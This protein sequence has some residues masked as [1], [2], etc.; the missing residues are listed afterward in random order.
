MDVLL[1]HAYFLYDDPHELAVMKPYPP[2]GLLYV[3]SH[4]KAHGVDSSIF[5][6]T[7]SRFDELE[8]CLLEQRPPVVGIYSNLMT[9][10]KVL[11]VIAAAKQAGSLVVV[12]GPDPANYLDEYL[13][14]GADVIAIGE[15]ELTLEEL[16][17][18]LQKFGPENLGGIQGIAFR[19]AA[20]AIVR[21]EP[22]PLIADLDAQPLPDRAAIDQHAYVNVWREHHGRGS[23]SLITARGCP[24]T[25]TWCS[26]SVFGYSHRRRTPA[27]VVDEVEHIVEAY[28]PDM[29]WY[30]D[31]V[32]TINHKWL[33][34]Y[35]D[36]MERR[37]IRLPFETIS[38]EDR[39]NEEVVQTLARMGC[40]RLWVGAES[41][42]QRVLDAMKRRT[43]AERMRAMVH[44]LQ[45]YG[46]EV[47]MFIMLGYEGE[48]RS[49][50]EETVEHLK[51]A[52]PDTFLT[53]VA[54]P[55]KGTPY[56][57]TVADRVVARR[58]WDEG[59]DRDYTVAGRHSARY[60]DFATRWM[61]S[62]VA[63]HRQ[64]H[65]PQRSYPRMAK[66]FVNARVGRLGM[67]I[68]ERQVERA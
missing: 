39:L 13:S 35:A 52:S 25:C 15:G 53:T 31:D 29:L 32:F 65:G 20:G 48:E 21:T 30:A 62:E 44:L 41:G 27:N 57:Q 47:G 14:R 43:N 51:L 37:G 17:P 16:V 56:Y 6:T 40:Y 2:L 22:R 60:Y 61:V 5:D 68:T 54:Y 42:S 49:D 59:S 7:F 58:A 9:R 8:S 23:V 33:F 34:E 4:L 1:T 12:G 38:R 19:D 63:L 10:S 28:A 36:Q 46:I 67:L 55:I 24:F 11:R 45:K 66:N 26:H 50:L 3:N 18:H 64:R